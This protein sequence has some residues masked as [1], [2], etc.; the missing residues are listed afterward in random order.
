MSKRRLLRSF[1]RQAQGYPPYA[2]NGIQFT[3]E[4]SATLKIKLKKITGPDAQQGGT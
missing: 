1:G 3:A 2:A 4:Q